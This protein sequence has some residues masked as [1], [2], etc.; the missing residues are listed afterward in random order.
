VSNR[1]IE[2]V[3]RARDNMSDAIMKARNSFKTLDKDARQAK[4]GIDWAAHAAGGAAKASGDLATE[5]QKASEA[6]RAAMQAGIGLR[7]VMMGGTT[8]VGGAAQ[9][10]RALGKE[11]K[12]LATTDIKNLGIGAIGPL[13]GAAVAGFKAG[14]ILDEKLNISGKISDWLVKPIEFAV[15]KSNE[16]FQ[17]LNE[18]KLTGLRKEVASV[19]AEFERVT[20]AANKLLSRRSEMI[21]ARSGEKMAAAQAI[22]DPTE[23]AMAV[24]KV[25]AESRE[26]GLSA[27]RTAVDEQIGAAQKYDESL[28][29]Q[30]QEIAKSRA[31]MSRKEQMAQEQ[32]RIAAEKGTL[33]SDSPAMLKLKET[34]AEA[35]SF[36]QTF[37]AQVQELAAAREKLAQEIADLTNKKIVVEIEA[38]TSAQTYKNEVA[39]AQKAHKEREDRTKQKKELDLLA[40]EHLGK[41]VHRAIKA[42]QAL[43]RGNLRDQVM[44]NQA[45]MQNAQGMLGDANNRVAAARNAVG[46]AWGWFRDP[47][48]FKAQ[49]KEEKDQAKAEEQFAREEARL[50]K[51]GDWRTKKLSAKDEAVRRMIFAKEEEA[52]AVDNLKNIERHVA[53]LDQIR[54]NLDKLLQAAGG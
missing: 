24:A 28:R 50:Q 44:G 51:M 35:A 17:K 26:Q 19:A 37:D 20:E 33:E 12:I 21:G 15:A 3:M 27:R 25:S 7:N 29:N 52:A 42:G 23:R 41:G 31:D 45:D 54:K 49:L 46:Q 43:V 8:A 53:Q 1:V 32:A 38:S 47:Q 9:M 39:A 14:Q 16:Y 18:I 10:V 4:A 22:A 11:L 34:R 2:W 5:Q 6:M 40:G 48:A 36:K 13:L 30:I